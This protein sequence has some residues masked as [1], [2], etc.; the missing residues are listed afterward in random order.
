MEYNKPECVSALFP[1][2]FWPLSRR[3][4][5]IVESSVT[6]SSDDKFV[7][8]SCHCYLNDDAMMTW[9]A[10]LNPKRGLIE[11]EQ[12]S[13]DFLFNDCLH[14]VNDYTHTYQFTAILTIIFCSSLL[15]GPEIPIPMDPTSLRFLR[16]RSSST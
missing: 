13:H 14:L 16:T 7:N 8:W 5:A 3:L 15:Q 11:T 9:C 2:F 10:V 1:H 6:P 4:G 12:Y